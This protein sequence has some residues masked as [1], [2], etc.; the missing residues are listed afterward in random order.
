M[1]QSS[2]CLE[3]DTSYEPEELIWEDD[4][5][6]AVELVKEQ[7][8]PSYEPNYYFRKTAEEPNLEREPRP[9]RNKRAPERWGYSW[10]VNEL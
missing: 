8:D 1:N 10:R 4:I 6:F 9:Q 7:Q 5:S 3:Q 2:K